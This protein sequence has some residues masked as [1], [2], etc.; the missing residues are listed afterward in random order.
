MA[1]GAGGQVRHGVPLQIGLRGIES[2]TDRADAAHRQILLRRAGQAQPDIRFAPRQAHGIGVGRQFQRD[3]GMRGMEGGD[4]R[5][6]NRDGEG[7]DGGDAHHAFQP[8]ITPG[9]AA[10]DAQRLVFHAFDIAEDRR[11]GCGQAEAARRLVQQHRPCARL[12]PGQSPPHRG[13]LDTQR[14]CRA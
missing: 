2:E 10:F 11:T 1:G 5:D 6:Q 3:A 7:F 13:L 14:P 12:Q 4:R 9:D 8:H